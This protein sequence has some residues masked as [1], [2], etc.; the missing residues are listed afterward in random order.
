MKLGIAYNIFYLPVTNKSIQLGI[1]NS[2]LISIF[3]TPLKQYR[4]APLP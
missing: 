1:F 2:Q 4:Y 3:S